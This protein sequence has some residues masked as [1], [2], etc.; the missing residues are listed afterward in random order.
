MSSFASAAEGDWP[1]WRGPNFDNV[2][3]DTGLLKEW[4]KDGPALAWKS[5]DV[6]AGFSSISIAGG[7]IFTMGE[8]GDSSFVVALDMTGKKLWSTKVGK[9]GGGGG[10]PGPRCTPTVDGE[11]LY[12][13][14]QYGDLVCLQAATGAELWRKNLNKDFGGKMMSGWG[15][16]E[17]PLVDGDRL[18]VTPGGKKGTV[19]ALNK[20]T[21]ETIWQS[22]DWTDDAAYTG[23]IIGTIAGKKQYVQFTAASVAGLNPETGDVLWKAERKGQTAVIPT[24]VV[25]NDHV[26]VTSG[27][28]VGCDLFKVTADGATFKV[29]KVYSNKNMVNHH[30][31]VILQDGK[32]YGYSDGKGWSCIDLLTGETVWKTKEELGKGAISYADGMFYLRDEGKSKGTIA[33]IEAS[34]EGYKEHGRFAPPKLS[35]KEQWP[36]LVIAGGKLYVRDQETLYCYDVKKK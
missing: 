16:S 8:A 4:P 14:G 7:K 9:T 25:H 20:L 23:V 35:G 34:K 18:I 22:D 15:N 5:T 29:E 30:G 32:I 28:G 33:L 13:V 10:Y 2:S 21:G 6:G 24:P 19:A 27:Y 11:H 31:G 3:P 17:S 36:H 12:A 26:F 1:R